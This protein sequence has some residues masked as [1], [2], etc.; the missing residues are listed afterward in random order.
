M[1]AITGRWY[2]HVLFS[3]CLLCYSIAPSLALLFPCKERTVPCMDLLRLVDPGR[4]RCKGSL[5]REV[6]F[7][8]VPYLYLRGELSCGQEDQMNLGAGTL[9]REQRHTC[10]HLLP[11]KPHHLAKSLPTGSEVPCLWGQSVS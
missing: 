3:I 1:I 10:S 4:R 7:Q 8:L 2:Y 11:P 9:S 6:C 5:K